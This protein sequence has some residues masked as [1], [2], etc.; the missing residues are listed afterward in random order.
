MRYPISSK[1]YLD[2]NPVEAHYVDIETT[3]SGYIFIAGEVIGRGVAAGGGEGKHGLTAFSQLPDLDHTLTQAGCT[4]MKPLLQ[5]TN[6]SEAQ[7]FERI[8]AYAA[9]AK[10]AD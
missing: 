10:H 2:R 5:Q 9:S 6:V 7:V 1:Q 4:W 3:D 8:I